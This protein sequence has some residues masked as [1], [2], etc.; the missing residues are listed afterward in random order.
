MMHMQ[1]ETRESM[2][3]MPRLRMQTVLQES[4]V[5]SD[6]TQDGRITSRW[7]HEVIMGRRRHCLGVFKQM[8][9]TH[10]SQGMYC[11]RDIINYPGRRRVGCMTANPYTS[12]RL[13]LLALQRTRVVW[14]D[15]KN[16][17]GTAASHKRAVPHSYGRWIYCCKYIVLELLRKLVKTWYAKT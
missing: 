11:N 12:I 14:A 15:R 16:H 7:K 5:W 2:I 10:F 17:A 3:E 13:W 1:V 9:K 6:T 4:S 8:C